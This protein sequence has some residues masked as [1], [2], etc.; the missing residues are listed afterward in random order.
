MLDSTL[1]PQFMTKAE[2]AALLRISPRTLSRWQAEG[3]GPPRI[4]CGKQ[5][6]FDRATLTTWFLAHQTKPPRCR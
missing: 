1:H 5:V 2:A 6:L 4:K 3:I